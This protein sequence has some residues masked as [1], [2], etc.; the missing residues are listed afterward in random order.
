[1]TPYNE[2]DREQT[3]EAFACRVAHESDG[4]C[5]Y[6]DGHPFADREP[7]KGKVLAGTGE[8][9]QRLLTARGLTCGYS[10]IKYEI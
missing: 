10:N 8:M 6:V 3:T 1:M 2:A 4:P 5:E 7:L 9:T